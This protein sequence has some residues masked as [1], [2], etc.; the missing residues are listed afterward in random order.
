MSGYV[1]ARAYLLIENPAERAADGDR[2]A[3]VDRLD[4]RADRRERLL[5]GRRGCAVR[6]AATGVGH[7]SVFLAHLPIISRGRDSPGPH[8]LLCYRGKLVRVIDVGEAGGNVAA[9]GRLHPVLG[10]PPVDLTP[11]GVNVGLEA[12]DQ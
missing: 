10:V 1:D 11:S 7:R 9:I 2:L 4:H 12:V 6:V 8:H 3:A 5:D